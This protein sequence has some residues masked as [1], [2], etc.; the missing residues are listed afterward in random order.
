MKR[1]C[2]I[3]LLVIATTASNA[4]TGAEWFNQKKTQKKYLL[5]QIAALRYYIDVAQKGY[6]IAKQGL[7][8]IGKLSKGE[9]DLHGEYFSSL[10]KVNPTVKKYAKVADII[11]LQAKIVQDYHKFYNG[12]ASEDV[13]TAREIDYL[14]RVFTRVLDDCTVLLDQLIAVTT[15]NQ[16]EMKDDE[17]M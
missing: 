9:F 6:G 15:D 14:E 8:T 7:S 13:F 2:M 4:Q 1:I 5:A 10:K 12:L 17:R 11:S 16:L 3:V